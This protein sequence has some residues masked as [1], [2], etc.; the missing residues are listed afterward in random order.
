MSWAQG[1]QNTS[2]EC[3]QM[4]TIN[5]LWIL[6]TRNFFFYF[7]SISSQVFVEFNVQIMPCQYLPPKA[8]LMLSAQPQE[9]QAKIASVKWSSPFECTFFNFHASVV[10]ESNNLLLKTPSTPTCSSLDK[11]C[12]LLCFLIESFCGQYPWSPRN[13]KVQIIHFT[14]AFLFH[15]V[16]KYRP[17]LHPDI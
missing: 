11:C 6:G 14:T 7:K 4:M 1:Q 15:P 5:G 3:K 13:G 12:L 17:S 9:A 2:S 16:S 10:T 8:Q